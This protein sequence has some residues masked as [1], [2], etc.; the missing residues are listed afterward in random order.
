M[1]DSYTPPPAGCGNMAGG[2]K[3]NHVA[4]GPKASTSNIAGG[5]NKSVVATKDTWS[6]AGS[7]G[8]RMGAVE[9]GITPLARKHT[10]GTA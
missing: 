10:A 1:I 6:P 5:L 4:V 2:A 9:S 7:I 3:Q 8:S